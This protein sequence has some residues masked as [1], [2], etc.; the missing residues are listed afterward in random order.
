M[1]RPAREDAIAELDSMA[2]M[3]KIKTDKN[4]GLLDSGETNILMYS[5]LKEEAREVLT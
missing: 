3:M 2:A 5:N 1:A 4:K